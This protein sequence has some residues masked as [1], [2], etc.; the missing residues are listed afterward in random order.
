MAS[1]VCADTAATE[2]VLSKVAHDLRNPINSISINAELVKLKLQQTGDP[3]QVVTYL[4]RILQECK[5]CGTV[6]ESSTKQFHD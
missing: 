3:A 2:E 1:K 4:D 5:N 6:L